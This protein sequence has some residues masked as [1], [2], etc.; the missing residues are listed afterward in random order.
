KP[1]IL[2]AIAAMLGAFFILGDPIFQGLAVSLIFGVFISTI[3]TLLVIPVL[4]FSYL[5]H[6]GGRVPGTVKA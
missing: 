2:T 1:I 4:Y 3:L 6:H 5:Q